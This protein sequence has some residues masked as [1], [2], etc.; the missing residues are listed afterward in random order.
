MEHILIVDDESIIAMHIEERLINMGYGVAGKAYSGEEAIRMAL[1][2]RPDLI[3]MDIMMP[4]GLDGIE[5]AEI[6]QAKLDVPIIFV[7]AYTDDTFITRAKPIQPYGYV[8]K[9]FQDRELR[10]IIE[11]TKYKREIEKQLAETQVA[12]RESEDRFR[13]IVEHAEAGYFM[14]D[15]TGIIRNVND[16]FVRMCKYESEIQVIGRNYR[17]FIAYP[18]DPQVAQYSRMVDAGKTVADGDVARKCSDGTLGYSNFSIT[19]IFSEGRI[20]GAEG[21]IIDITGRKL[22]E[23]EMKR[24]NRALKVLS[25]ANHSV[26]A[27]T[28]EKELLQSICQTI[29]T[30]GGYRLAWI[31]FIE[32]SP[33]RDVISVSQVSYT[34]QIGESVEIDFRGSTFANGS[35]AAGP[36][37]TRNILN[38]PSCAPLR[39]EA[40]KLGYAASISLP[41][42]YDDECIGVLNIFAAEP[43]AFDT[44]ENKLLNELADNLAFGVV[45]LRTR[46]MRHLAEEKL[47][48]SEELHRKLIAASPDTII[49]TDDHGQITFASPN[50]VNSHRCPS[51]GEVIGAY[52]YDFIA[53]EER[54]SYLRNFQRTL[55]RGSC[56]P[57]EFK[58]IAK[59]G[60]TY[61][62]EINSAVLSNNDGKPTGLVLVSRDNTERIIAEQALRDNEEKYRALFELASDAIFLIDEDSS[63]IIDANNAAIDLYGYSREDIRSLDK[64]QLSSADVPLPE[65]ETPQVYQ[66]FHRK[67]DGTVFP[68]EIAVAQ[69]KFKDRNMS[70]ASCRDITERKQ[71][72]DALRLTQFTVDNSFDSIIWVNNSGKIIYANKA[73]CSSLGYTHEELLNLDIAD[74]YH[75]FDAEKWEAIWVSLREKGSGAFETAFRR[76]DRSTFPV[77]STG[78]YFHYFGF[79]IICLFSRDISERKRDEAL[80]RDREQKLSAITSSTHDAIVMIDRLGAILFWNPAAEK[81]FGY[82]SEEI[83]S[84]DLRRLFIPGFSEI[85]NNVDN[86]EFILSTDSSG[87]KALEFAAI[88]K[89]GIAF[90]VEI[91]I[92]PI[93]NDPHGSSVMAVRDITERKQSEERVRKLLSELETANSEL[94]AF[95]YMAS[96]DL[97][98]PLVSIEGF[99]EI[100]LEDFSDRLDPE[101]QRYFQRIR[102]SINRMKNMIDGLLDYSRIGRVVDEKHTIPFNRLVAEALDSLAF[103]IQSRG[104]QVSVQNSDAILSCER[105]RMQQVLTNL[106]SNAIKYI[107]KNNPA[108][109]IEIGVKEID[110]QHAFYVSD[111]GIGISPQCHQRI[112]QMFGRVD[113]KEDIEGTGVGLAIVKR[114]IEQHQ[115]RIWVHSDIGAG[116]TFYFTIN[117]S[118]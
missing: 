106:I 71:M 18:G 17:D 107:G 54:V 26:V 55:E 4:N 21:F 109:R 81:M 60:T 35:F 86:S 20:V 105:L 83:I 104:V 111:N 63:C 1:E 47:R 80:I 117:D 87:G 69:F 62:R 48:V 25:S 96:H 19:P 29:V 37:V 118:M 40:E 46:I 6:I 5:A 88:D 102:N 51:A 23:M 84:H 66:R 3:L 14:I 12:L 115:G 73:T 113:M 53:P 82:S 28:D 79:E 24:L 15:D 34:G 99:T 101:A 89:T 33:D 103:M 76:K 61:I 93:L 7:T 43:D 38:D 8:V 49:V 32:Q 91:K 13:G 31:G 30:V 64:S 22:A 78:D 74:W 97:K 72:E 42:L 65:K 75:E 114:I 52:I 39:E 100:L 57:R 77:E 68:V 94:Q 11:I 116:S 90:P 98:S 59:D 67:K 108:P 92:S 16:A 110:G 9:P 27:A 112:F 41:L 95:A 10:A 85:S 36:Q 44:E 58:L 70:L 50:I 2:L 45:T 56:P